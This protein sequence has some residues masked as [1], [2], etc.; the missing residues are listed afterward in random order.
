MKLLFAVI[1]VLVSV[2]RAS[3]VCSSDDYDSYLQSYPLKCG[4]DCD[5]YKK[6]EMS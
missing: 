1:A 4:N 6:Y 3:D 2:C 5:E